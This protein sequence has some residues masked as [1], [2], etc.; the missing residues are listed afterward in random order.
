MS[1]EYVTCHKS[2]SH[3]TRVCHMSQEYVT[4]H[5]SMS[6]VTRVCHMSQEYVT[7]HISMSHVTSVCHMSPMS[8]LH[9][10]WLIFKHML[11]LEIYC[12][13]EKYQSMKKVP[14]GP[15]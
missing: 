6:H 15:G 8:L 1:Q 9:V 5:I 14:K 4:C 10:T 12:R 2:M 3:V 13:G 7:C 11:Y